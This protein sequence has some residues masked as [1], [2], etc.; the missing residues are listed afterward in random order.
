M[1]GEEVLSTKHASGSP[2]KPRKGRT[3]VPTAKGQVSFGQQRQGR[4]TQGTSAKH[5]PGC[6]V[7]SQWKGHRRFW[8]ALKTN[9]MSMAIQ[10]SRVHLHRYLINAR[11]RRWH[12]TCHGEGSRRTVARVQSMAFERRSRFCGMKRACC[13]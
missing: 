2:K 7:T 10:D 3:S 11:T 4:R 8:L 5:A 1:E 6:R 12:F 9:R 13:T